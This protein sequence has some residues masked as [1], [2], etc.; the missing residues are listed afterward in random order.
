MASLYLISVGVNKRSAE[1]LGDFLLVL[2]RL[3]RRFP[4]RIKIP[5]PH[6]QNQAT[7]RRARRVQ[8]QFLQELGLP[9][10]WT[11][12]L[13]LYC[14]IHKVELI[15]N[16]QSPFANYS[17]LGIGFKEQ[18]CGLEERFLLF[19]WVFLALRGK[20]AGNIVCGRWLFVGVSSTGRWDLGSR[21]GG[22]N[23]LW[24]GPWLFVFFWTRRCFKLYYVGEGECEF[25]CTDLINWSNQYLRTLFIKSNKIERYFTYN[26]LCKRL[27]NLI[28]RF[29]DAICSM[30]I[31]GAILPL[32]C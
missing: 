31:K 29:G 10:P 30:F 9:L 4:V 1:S 25:G 8:Y 22:V 2:H 5:E 19:I 15:P 14:R 26:K 7:Q 28:K 21:F 24:D 13:K 16:F 6:E 3:L 11:P 18:G 12:H 27:V 17:K 32:T 23:V 20:Q